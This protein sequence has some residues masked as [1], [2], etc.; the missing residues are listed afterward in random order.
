VRTLVW[1]R[2]KDLRLADHEPLHA[3]LRSGEVV[4][5]FV[6]D[7]YFFSPERA[8][9]LAHRMQFLLESLAELSRSIERLGS[10]LLVVRGRST[11]V[12]P[13]LARR[14]KC[15]RVVAHRWTEPFARERDRRV[16]AALDP[17]PF[18]LH[19]GETL[20]PAGRL[21]S[22]Q[23]TPFAVFSAF[24]RAFRAQVDVAPPLPAPK[25]LP[26][27]PPD[28]SAA[29]R[30][31][32]VP[33]PSLDDLRLVHNPR[34]VRGG[35]SEAGKRLARF[36]KQA[37]ADYPAARDVLPNAT[38]TSRLSVDLK[39]GTISARTVWSRVS[40]RAKEPPL[41]AASEKFLTEV[42]WRE[43][44]H[45]TLWDRPELLARPFRRDFEGFP[46]RRDRAA[47]EAWTAGTTG[48]PV[49]DAAARQLLAEGYVHNRA[50]MIAASF[51]AKHLLLDFRLGEA[52][53]L[54]HLVDGDWAQND[55]GWQWSAGCGCD[56]QPWFR[57]FHPVTQGK[58]HDPEGE[59][60]RRWVPELA[61]MPAKWIHAPWEAPDAVLAA[62]G[63]TL[64]SS[65]PRPI[66]DHA[67]ARQ[68]F[69]AVTKQ[70]L[71]RNAE[72]A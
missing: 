63:V 56:A 65:Y 68:R 7:P 31:D 44:A 36:E 1:F 67:E 20:A 38:G 49:V 2:G 39:F 11:E 28:V 5:L 26:P 58:R 45:A 66:V 15:D 3:A 33:I 50:R 29:A 6:L 47:W 52:H 62:A 34:L 18:E 8:A 19:E 10:R 59:Y 42:L 27:L 21:R 70:H 72:V 13:A 17:I 46:W 51:L 25:Q 9:G 16:T 61:R 32:E 4:P 54:Q 14:W 22:G 71:G 43:F 23:G 57:I 40:L 30:A 24:A 60:V 55:L 69:L 35:E 53:Y 37:L 41:A 64:G 48:Y 12:V